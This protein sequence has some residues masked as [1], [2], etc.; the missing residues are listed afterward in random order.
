MPSR[1]RGQSD[2]GAPLLPGSP[3][4]PLS[5]GQDGARHHDALGGVQAA[6]DG[7]E[8][9]DGLWRGGVVSGSSRH[10][11]S[12]FVPISMHLDSQLGLFFLVLKVLLK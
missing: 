2:L 9:R 12:N 8:E 5:A 6:R 11:T 10:G 1:G 3:G 7:G 4:L